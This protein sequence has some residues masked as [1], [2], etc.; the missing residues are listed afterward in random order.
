MASGQTIAVSPSTLA[1]LIE[2]EVA[3]YVE[4]LGSLVLNDA[5]RT[6]ILESVQLMLVA[7]RA[8]MTSRAHAALR[9]SAATIAGEVIVL[10]WYTRRSSHAPQTKGG[11]LCPSPR[12]S[13]CRCPSIV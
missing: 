4:Q 8:H 2:I 7:G 11:V 12:S 6:T 10:P 13:T 9:A 3:N 1:A 5:Q